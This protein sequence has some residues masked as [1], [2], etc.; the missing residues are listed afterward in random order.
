MKVENPHQ[1][2]DGLI[3]DYCDGTQFRSHPLFSVDGKALQLMLYYDDLETCNPL[4]SKFSKHKLG[5]FKI[6]K[7]LANV[8]FLAIS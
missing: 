4:G 6:L 5:K 2:N 3:R 7:N 8:Q 1:S